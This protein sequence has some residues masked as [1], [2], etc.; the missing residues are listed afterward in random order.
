MT[1]RA[2]PRLEN[3]TVRKLYAT[4]VLG[5]LMHTLRI[6]VVDDWITLMQERWTE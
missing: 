5:S 3:H 6:I 4:R 2:D 1:F